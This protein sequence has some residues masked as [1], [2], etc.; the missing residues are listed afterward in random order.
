MTAREQCIMIAP[1]VPNPEGTGLEQR[2][3]SLLRDL[4]SRFD[5]TLLVAN[6]DPNPPPAPAALQSLTAAIQHVQTRRASRWARRAAL[7][8]PALVLLNPNW[9]CDWQLPMAPPATLPEHPTQ[10]AFF[11]LRTHPLRPA[12]FRSGPPSPTLIDLDD[13]ESQTLWSIG[14]FA[15]RRGRFLLALKHLSMAG[16]YALLERTLLRRYD[17]VTYANPADRP[18]LERVA[19]KATLLCRPN[20]VCIPPRASRPPI[21]AP[22]TLLFLGSLGYF[23]NEDAVLWLAGELVPRL[24]RRGQFSFRLLI[25]GRGATQQLTARLA[26][27]PEVQFLGPVQHVAPLYAQS[28]LAVAAVR[29][30]GGTKLKVLE[31]VAHRC[32]VVTTPH[33]ALGLPFL[34]GE[35]LLTASD[36]ETFAACCIR[37]ANHPNEA[38]A[39]AQSAYRRLTASPS[40]AGIESTNMPPSS[41]CVRSAN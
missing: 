27:I 12:I 34:P 33:S 13:R 1:V 19:R 4:A 17:A 39:M 7:C 11:R 25:A 37:L 28:H 18:A 9:T 30:G 31:A 2:A 29:C 38:I 40:N 41:R 26:L 10:V 3:F 21:D 24:R 23:P 22:F 8:L 5:V 16:Q 14:C 35:D 6:E 36:A 20:R 32:P 15:L